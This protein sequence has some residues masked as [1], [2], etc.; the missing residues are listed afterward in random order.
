MCLCCLVF[1]PTEAGEGEGGPREVLL[2]A[3]EAHRVAQAATRV[4]QSPCGTVA[5][6]AELLALSGGPAGAAAGLRGAICE[7]GDGWGDGSDGD[8]DDDEDEDDD[9][10]GGGGGGGGGGA[11]ARASARRARGARAAAGA[12]AAPPPD[13]MCY[14]VIGN[15]HRVRA[16]LDAR[17]WAAGSPVSV[18]AVVRALQTAAACTYPPDA[19][20]ALLA[21]AV[22]G[23]GGGVDAGGPGSREQGRWQLPVDLGR[24]EQQ[25]DVFLMTLA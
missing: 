2:G 12:G 19:L 25:L 20:A 5:E 21:R 3:V 16:E 11:G 10:G 8:E 23:A 7:D 13:R 1:G 24:L 6:A 15:L 4:V 22:S 18:A 17:G 9:D 14:F